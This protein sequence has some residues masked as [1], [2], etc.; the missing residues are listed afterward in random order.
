MNERTLEQRIDEIEQRNQRVENDKAWERSIFRI[1][2]I[3]ALTYGFAVLYIWLADTTN[4][5][6]G[7]VVPTVGFL[8]SVQS[9][10]LVKI[11]W[12]KIRNK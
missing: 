9:L 1:G 8:L 5:F 4:P 6:L 3:L 10:K 11:V 7:A 12:L 2:F